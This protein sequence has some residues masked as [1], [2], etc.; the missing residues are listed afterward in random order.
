MERVLVLGAPGS[1]KSTLAAAIARQAGLPLVHLDQHYWRPGW[2]EPDPAEW[3]RQVEAL[4]AGE[5]WAM[6]G[7]YGGTLAPRLARAD[8]I[9]WLDFPTWLC[10]ARIAG[11]ALRH[12][13]RVRA[14]M[15]QG[16]PERLEWEFFAY[17]AT[18]RRRARR[19]IVEHLRDFPGTIVRLRRPREV[20]RFLAGLA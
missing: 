16:C 2:V 7:N 1:G 13:G 5:R 3:L 4:A 20:A 19:R 8:T 17:T 11:R 18:F 14:D 12:H 6:D 15:A 10:L 9:V